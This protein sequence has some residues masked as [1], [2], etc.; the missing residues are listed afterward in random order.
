MALILLKVLL[1]D[2]LIIGFSHGTHLGKK[3][4]SSQR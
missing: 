3:I 2:V 1:I 4:Q